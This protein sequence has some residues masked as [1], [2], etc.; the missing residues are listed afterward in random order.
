[1]A[2][3]GEAEKALLEAIALIAKRGGEAQNRAGGE[4]V[5]D[6]AIAYRAVVGGQQ[7]GSVVVKNG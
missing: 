7:P 6:A 1:M 3:Q 5:R 2:T 4:M